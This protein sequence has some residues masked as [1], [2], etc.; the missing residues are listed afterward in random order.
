MV[1]VSTFP[2]KTVGMVVLAIVIGGGVGVGIFFL[3]KFLRNREP[4]PKVRKTQQDPYA[5]RPKMHRPEMLQALDRGLE[6]D[7]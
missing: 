7:R 1:V 2:W 3:V 5:D 4:K 6:D